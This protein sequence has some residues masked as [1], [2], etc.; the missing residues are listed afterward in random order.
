M[1][2]AWFPLGTGTPS[3][4]A[5]TGRYCS[6]RCSPYSRP[7]LL[8]SQLHLPPR[9]PWRACWPPSFC[10]EGFICPQPSTVVYS[11]FWGKNKQTKGKPAHQLVVQN[12]YFQLFT[13]IQKQL[14]WI[15]WKMWILINIHNMRPLTFVSSHFSNLPSCLWAPPLLPVKQDWLKNL[16]LNRS[17][18]VVGLERDFLASD[19]RVNSGLHEGSVNSAA[20]PF[21][22]GKSWKNEF[23]QHP[24]A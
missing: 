2:E 20:R 4:H 17:T 5:G 19:W 22:A 14:S 11:Q 12:P 10:A 24:G 21:P 13:F 23:A 3:V 1:E 18:I 16:V 15:R 9:Q 8:P 6:P 7:A